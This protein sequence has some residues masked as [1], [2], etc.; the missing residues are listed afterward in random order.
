MRRR[1]PS[2][3]FAGTLLAGG[4]WVDAWGACLTADRDDQIA[5]GR[6]AYM[7]FVDF[8]GRKEHAYIGELVAPACLDGK[9]DIDKVESTRR[10]HVYSMDT[11]LRGRMRG[12]VGRSV[13]VKGS[14]FGEHTVYHHAPIVM[15]I[16]TI[17]RR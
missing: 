5:E 11:K 12:L 13:R 7:L 9:N 16:V 4:L 1:V 8:A 14:P 2:T 3:A 17:E 6:L 15:N 10:I